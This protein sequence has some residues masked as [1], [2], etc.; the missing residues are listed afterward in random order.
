MT[1]FGISTTTG[2]TAGRGDEERLLDRVGKVLD[3]LTRNC[4]SRRA[5]DADRVDL[6]EGIRADHRVGTWPVRM[7]IGMESM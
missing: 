4:A 6:L 5:R 1:S 3:V 7:T 2:R